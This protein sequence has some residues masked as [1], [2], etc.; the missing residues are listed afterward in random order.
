MIG[1]GEGAPLLRSCL[2]DPVEISGILA[3]A[4]LLRLSARH[5]GFPLA[6]L[7]A[8]ACGLP[9]VATNVSGVRDVFADRHESGGSLIPPNDPAAL[10]AEIR[11]V[12]EDPGVLRRMGSNARTRAETFSTPVV[13]APVR[14][15]VLGSAAR[16][17]RSFT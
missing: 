4:D 12:L 1:T 15:F 3:A 5:E 6:P 14:D 11:P 16:A 9:V 10:A 2:H 8:M 7:E 17:A 13:G